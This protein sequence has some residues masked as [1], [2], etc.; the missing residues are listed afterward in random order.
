MKILL[1]IIIAIAGIII[2]LLIIG[3]FLKK[4]YSISTEV[5]INKPKA[6][7]FDFLK[8]LKNQNKFSVWASLD[9]NENRIPGN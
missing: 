7:V 9:P 4:D 1:G 8:F 5:I 3:L 2:L 6:A